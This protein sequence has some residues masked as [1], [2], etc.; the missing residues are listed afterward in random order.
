MSEAKQ[1][2]T[3]WMR[4]DMPK[5]ATIGLRVRGGRVVAVPMESDRWLINCQ[6]D[7]LAEL[8]VQM[9][10]TLEVVPMNP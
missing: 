1:E 6:I 2:P 9:G 7:A 10:W 4:L 3:I 8:A 5:L